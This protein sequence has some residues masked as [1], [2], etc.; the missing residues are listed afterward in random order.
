MKA[1][2]R[3]DSTKQIGQQISQQTE[4]TLSYKEIE[5]TGVE[6]GKLQSYVSLYLINKITNNNEACNNFQ[7][8]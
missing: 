6:L 3:H 1:V 2:M 4:H 7:D 8:R 5:T